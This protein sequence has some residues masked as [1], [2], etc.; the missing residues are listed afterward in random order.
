MTR[1]L[2]NYPFEIDRRMGIYSITCNES[3]AV[4]IGSACNFF[5][6]WKRHL[7]ELNCGK[8]LNTH[9]QRAWDKYGCEGFT[10][11]IVEVVNAK[12]DLLPTEQRW[13]DHLFT[14]ISPD[15]RFN[16]C[17][18]AG[19]HLGIKRSAETR[20]RMSEAAKRRGNTFKY[21]EAWREKVSRANHLNAAT[22]CGP[23][24]RAKMSALKQG[25]TNCLGYVWVYDSQGKRYR[26]KP[27][28]PRL[29]SGELAPHKAS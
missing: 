4:Y 25:N 19:S 11:S 7:N 29:L 12:E 10:W 26:V 21:D 3:G 9:L 16:M 1:P 27:D 8:H 6:R 20:A 13:L 5:R 18:V 15:Q 23:A 28:D 17:R 24:M 14:T 2:G 22:R